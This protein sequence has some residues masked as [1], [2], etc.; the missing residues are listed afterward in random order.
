M[1][2]AGGLFSIKVHPDYG[3]YV[4][5]TANI[6]KKATV[7]EEMPMM[8]A[9]WPID[10]KVTFEEPLCLGCC[11][12]MPRKKKKPMDRATEG[13]D[14]EDYMKFGLKRCSKCTWP[15]CCSECEEMSYH[16]QNECQ[17]FVET[18]LPYPPPGEQMNIVTASVLV[19]LIRCLL[20]KKRNYKLWTQHV[21]KLQCE[22]ALGQLPWNFNLLLDD[23]QDVFPELETELG[24]REECCKLLS[25]ININAFSNTF[26]N[27]GEFSGCSICLFV[28]ASMIAHSCKNNSYFKQRNT[29]Y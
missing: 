19:Q 20:V 13:D 12:H 10:D 22:T 24:S 1:Y 18:R 29:T 27:E 2:S 5:T 14:I 17:L 21:L 23:I 28:D 7:L 8:C 3:R 25:I 11:M 4:V 26:S 16:S 15:I 6:T 9:P